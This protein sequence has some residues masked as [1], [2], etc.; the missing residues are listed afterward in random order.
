LF[1]CFSGHQPI[2]PLQ[3]RFVGGSLEYSREKAR[4]WHQSV[5]AKEEVSIAN[6]T[7]RSFYRP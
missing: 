6:L 5:L 4:K 3:L 7:L 1:S 2:F